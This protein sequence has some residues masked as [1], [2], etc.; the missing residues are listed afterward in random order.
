MKNKVRQCER[1][2]V[3]ELYNGF[4]QIEETG[5]PRR[6]WGEKNENYVKRGLREEHLVNRTVRNRDFELGRR[7]ETLN[8]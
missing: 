4:R 3:I 6:T 5:I 8:I 1:T 2:L 7:G